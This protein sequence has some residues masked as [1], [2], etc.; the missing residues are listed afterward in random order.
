MGRVNVKSAVLIRAV[1]AC[2]WCLWGDPG[3]GCC[4]L[5]LPVSLRLSRT[6]E[7]H[8]GI[9]QAPR[10]AL[11]MQESRGEQDRR[12]IL[13]QP[14]GP[15]RQSAAGSSCWLTAL[16]GPISQA[17]P[18]RSCPSGA[19]LHCPRALR[20]QHTSCAGCGEGLRPGPGASAH[21]PFSTAQKAFF[22]PRPAHSRADLPRPPPR[23]A[24][25]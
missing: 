7:M 14:V 4:F 6:P 20:A 9:S 15:G 2:Q 25:V 16:E 21:S 5:Q 11:G 1:V 12:N 10:G 19:R 22:R 24:V 18:G 17:G 3:E 8:P 23:A 13:D